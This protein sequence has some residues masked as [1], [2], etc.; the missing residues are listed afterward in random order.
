MDS[1]RM[2]IDF[3]SK[4]ELVAGSIIGIYG[5]YYSNNYFSY[6]YVYSIDDFRITLIALDQYYQPI[7]IN[8][9][10]IQI[11][12]SL[13][14]Y[15]IVSNEN[16]I[17]ITQNYFQNF[18]Q[19]RII[20]RKPRYGDLLL[21][22]NNLY[23]YD[24][25][26]VLNYDPISGS[27]LVVQ[28]D[29][30]NIYYYNSRN[31]NLVLDLCNYYVISTKELRRDIIEKSRKIKASLKN[32]NYEPLNIFNEIDCFNIYMNYLVEKTET[33]E[34]QLVELDF[35]TSENQVSKPLEDL[36][37]FDGLEIEKKNCVETDGQDNILLYH[38]NSSQNVL[39]EYLRCYE[40]SLQNIMD[41]D[42]PIYK[43]LENENE[44]CRVYDYWQTNSILRDES[45]DE[46]LSFYD[47][48]KLILPYNY[49]DDS[50]IESNTIVDEKY[51]YNEDL[52][53]LYDTDEEADMKNMETFSNYYND[54]NNLINYTSDI[55][56]GVSFDTSYE[57]DEVDKINMKDEVAE[58]D[59]INMKDE[60][61]EDEELII[62]EKISDILQK[63]APVFENDDF[64][65]L[66]KDDFEPFHV[67]RGCSIM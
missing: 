14:N 65:T 16:D 38:E 26:S 46:I 55:D 9:E 25:F 29:Y 3:F 7:I 42:N 60:A 35:L 41:N 49:Y 61:A 10:F 57:A 59:K 54:T 1:E 56:E 37:K 21:I 15:F 8:P 40:E 58:V 31:H 53:K 19:N 2:P 30:S 12:I 64:E 6:W 28:V 44:G 24:V 66:E 5:T 32:L 23:N 11:E 20:K 67:E 4:K 51:I 27:H 34:T 17:V 50:S 62:K 43:Y 63:V 33:R 36:I 13:I 45:I 39:E 22:K 48:R 47:Q 52:I 18:Y